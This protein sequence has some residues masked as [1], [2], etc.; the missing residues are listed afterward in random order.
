[1]LLNPEKMAEQK[2]AGIN[3][4]M[5]DTTNPAMINLAEVEAGHSTISQDH[6]VVDIEM[7]KLKENTL[8]N[9]EEH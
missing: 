3:N 7:Q 9:D 4:G 5:I 1:M 6:I 2:D 8:Q